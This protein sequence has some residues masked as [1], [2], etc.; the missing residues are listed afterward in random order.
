MS[1]IRAHHNSFRLDID[2]TYIPIA[3]RGG[4]VQ[5]IALWCDA[6][7]EHRINQTNSSNL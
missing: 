5:C 2:R 6:H 1:L 3:V 4:A 7:N